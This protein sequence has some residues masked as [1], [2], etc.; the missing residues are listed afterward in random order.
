MLEPRSTDE[1]VRIEKC[2]L[3]L[4]QSPVYALN[5]RHIA[6]GHSFARD[7]ERQATVFLPDIS[8]VANRS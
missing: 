3:N 6:R 2:A 8:S 1:A 5:P 7:F 4:H